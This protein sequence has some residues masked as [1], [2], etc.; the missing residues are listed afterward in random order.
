[1]ASTDISEAS[2]SSLRAHTRTRHMGT[3]ES[4]DIN[5]NAT[6]KIRVLPLQGGLKL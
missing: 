3:N 6:R 1:M 2:E 4:Y 5:L